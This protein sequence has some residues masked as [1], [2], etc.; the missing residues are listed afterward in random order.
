M[1]ESTIAVFCAEVVACLKNKKY[2]QNQS[3]SLPQGW[4]YVLVFKM[5][6]LCSS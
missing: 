3:K 5:S 6:R 4:R 1:L 2:A